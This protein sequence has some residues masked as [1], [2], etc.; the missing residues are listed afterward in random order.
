MHIKLPYR[1]SVAVINADPGKKVAFVSRIMWNESRQREVLLEGHS[2]LERTSR[3]LQNSERV[4]I[5]TEEIST[6]IMRELGVQG[7][8]LRGAQSRLTEIDSSLSKSRQVLSYMHR[9]VFMN[10][11]LLIFVII[12]EIGII[13][14]I[15]YLKYLKK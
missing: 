5:Q 11:M 9:N 3:S 4:A 7:E 15:V 6:G 10:K 14:C 13:A 2:A 8:T 1:G 12:C